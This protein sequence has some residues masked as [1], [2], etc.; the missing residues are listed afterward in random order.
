MTKLMLS[1]DT[2]EKLRQVGQRVEVVD[3]GG[4]PLGHFTPT[5]VSTIYD[6]VRIPF[7]LEELNRFASEPG[8]RTLAEIMADLEKQS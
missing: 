5:G 1:G 8:G 3:E 7:S 4:N 2:A 6:D